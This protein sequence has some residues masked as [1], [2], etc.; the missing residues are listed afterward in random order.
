MCCIEK[1]TQKRL[2]THIDLNVMGTPVRV[3]L[4]LLGLHFAYNTAIALGIAHVLGVDVADSAHALS[5][6]SVPG[7]RMRVLHISDGEV[8]V[9][10][11]TYNANPSSMVAALTTIGAINVEG[12]R[13][14]VLG[15]MLEMGPDSAKYHH[16]VGR[17]AARAGFTMIYGVG[18]RAGDIVEGAKQGGA[19]GMVCSSTDDAIAK[20]LVMMHYGDWILCKGSRGMR[21]ER[22]VQGLLEAAP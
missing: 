22:V 14:A 13:I 20:L 11:D 21:M 1:I 8:T 12:E 17:E 9:V 15:D 19:D 3:D 4:P 6:S 18:E 2:Q 5:T 16:D 7:G 10:D